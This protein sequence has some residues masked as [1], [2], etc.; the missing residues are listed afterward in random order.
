MIWNK[1]C[2]LFIS[3]TMLVNLFIGLPP[4]NPGTEQDTDTM[5][6]LHRKSSIQEIHRAAACAVRS[7]QSSQCGS[8]IL[9]RGIMPIRQRSL[10]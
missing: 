5:N 1:L 3:I 4:F 2:A 8:Y 6:I 7:P 9:T 10:I